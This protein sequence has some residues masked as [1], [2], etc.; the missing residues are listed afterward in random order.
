M[1][2]KHVRTA[3]AC[4]RF[5]ATA[6]STV[7][8]LNGKLGIF[9]MSAFQ[10]EG[11]T[12]TLADRWSITTCLPD[13]AK[14]GCAVTGFCRCGAWLSGYALQLGV[15]GSLLDQVKEQLGTEKAVSG[16]P[17]LFCALS[18]TNDYKCTRKEDEYEVRRKGLLNNP[19]LSNEAV[20]EKNAFS[21]HH[22]LDPYQVFPQ[23]T[24]TNDG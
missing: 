14:T 21:G 6:L 8:H 23:A 11:S 15:L 22:L 12:V 3:N 10:K 24:T 2:V 20:Q 4:A 7:K 5:V 13:T 19:C 1:S 17:G 18:C 16:V 9:T